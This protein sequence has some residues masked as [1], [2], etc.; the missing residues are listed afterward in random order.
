MHQESRK[1]DIVRRSPEEI[2]RLLE[3][4]EKDSGTSVKEFCQLHG[5]RE[6]TYYNWRKRFR[7]DV[8]MPPGCCWQAIVYWINFASAFGLVSSVGEAIG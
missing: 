1:K 6:A 8:C 5:I 7:P 3:E 2:Q 4:F